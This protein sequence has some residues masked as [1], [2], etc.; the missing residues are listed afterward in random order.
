M[1]KTG[2]NCIKYA[3]VWTVWT[4]QKKWI[5]LEINSVWGDCWFYSKDDCNLKSIL[6]WDDVDLE[7]NVF[8][9]STGTTLN[10][11]CGKGMFHENDA[12]SYMPTTER[13]NT[14]YSHA[15]VSW[16]GTYSL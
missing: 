7:S 6:E 16:Q 1:A 5:N 3:S 4:L 9:T 2:K 11:F 14:G 13:K 8:T 15:I 10:W 12:H